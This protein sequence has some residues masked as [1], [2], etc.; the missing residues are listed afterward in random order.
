MMNYG[1]EP[2]R[3]LPRAHIVLKSPST[4]QE[5]VSRPVQGWA[6]YILLLVGFGMQDGSSMR[7]GWPAGSWRGWMTEPKVWGRRRTS[8]PLHISRPVMSDTIPSEALET[9]VFTASYS[10]IKIPQSSISTNIVLILKTEF[11]FRTSGS[12]AVIYET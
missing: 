5:G 4:L 6:H 3:L 7:F 1:I 2:A 12:T 8:L 10:M 9:N 11:H